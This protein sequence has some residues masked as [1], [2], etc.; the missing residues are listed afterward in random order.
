MKLLQL[1]YFEQACKFGNISHAAEALHI[2]Q[3]SVSVAIQELEKEFGVVLLN[4]HGRSFSLTHEGK[5]F[6]EQAQALLAHADNLK[7]FGEGLASGGET[8]R[9]GVPPMIGAVLL[10]QLF[11]AMQRKGRT[12]RI[13]TTEG[14]GQ[15]LCDQ[16]KNYQVDMAVVSH[17]TPFLEFESQYITDMS[18]SCCTSLIHPLAQR[19]QVSVQDLVDEKLV[20]FGSAFFSTDQVLRRFQESGIK[21]NIMVKTGQVS[22]MV[23]IISRNVAVGFMLDK[24]VKYMRDIVCIPLSPV[25]PIKV[26]LIWQKDMP[27][28]PTKREFMEL[29]RTISI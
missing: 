24:T 16:V 4:R 6:L 15:F 13:E 27:I 28:S 17:D 29:I 8:I 22:T 10:P 14:G 26:S 1:R 3:P 25:V 5:V 9:L 11:A 20:L 2:S 18:I 21:P 23:R 7:Q 19:K 12:F